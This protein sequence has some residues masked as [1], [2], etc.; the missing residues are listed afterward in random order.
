MAANCST[1]KFKER[2][3]WTGTVQGSQPKRLEE[4][5]QRSATSD[6]TMTHTHAENNTKSPM[7]NGRHYKMHT[8]CWQRWHII[9][10]CMGRAVSRCINLDCVTQLS[11]LR[12][13]TAHCFNWVAK[14]S[15]ENWP[16]RFKNAAPDPQTGT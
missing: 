2:T 13:V 1:P 7:Y 16:R 14:N 9:T 4:K 12:P 15:A 10:C 6:N 11:D 3:N 5:K 8:L